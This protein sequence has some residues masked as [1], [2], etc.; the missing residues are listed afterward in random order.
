[1]LIIAEHRTL[2]INKEVQRSTTPYSPYL[3]M[4][5]IVNSITNVILQAAPFWGGS[6]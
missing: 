1:M 3:V 4:T 6:F 5:N 2:I